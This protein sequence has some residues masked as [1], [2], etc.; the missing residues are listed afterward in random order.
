MKERS[1]LKYLDRAPMSI[2]ERGGEK[3]LSTVAL[4]QWT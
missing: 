1:D 4:M 3:E 2:G